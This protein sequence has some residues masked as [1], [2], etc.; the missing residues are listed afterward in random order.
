MDGAR[1]SNRP[2]WQE[3]TAAAGFLRARSEFRITREAEN[4]AVVIGVEGELDLGQVEQLQAELDKAEQSDVERIVLDLNRVSFIDSSGIALLVAATR[5]SA[6]DSDR[7]RIKRPK[8]PD[9]ERLLQLT[10]V[11]ERL[12]FLG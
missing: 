3:E 7:L 9:V 1:G 4:G 5:R 2:A 10:G 6:K 8:S 12:P 11:I